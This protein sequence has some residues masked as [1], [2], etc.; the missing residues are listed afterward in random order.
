MIHD[1]VRKRELVR[2]EK[3]RRDTKGEDGE[4]EID[5]PVAPEGEGGKE[6]KEN[7]PHAKVDAGPS[8]SGVENTKRN[9]RSRK[10]TTRRD[11]PRTTERQVAR[12]GVRRNPRAEH[13]EGG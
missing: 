9:S 5:D 1:E 3:A 7:H 12:D 13:F 8:E 11:V 6:Q 4:P 2:G 10:A